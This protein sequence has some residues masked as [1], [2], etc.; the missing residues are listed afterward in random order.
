[1]KKIAI[2][3]TGIMG[4]GMA[5][6]FLKADHEVFVW[7]RNAEKL[8]P[9]LGK[10]AKA[11]RTP[12]DTAAA[13]DIVFEVT[14][15]EESSRAVWL[16]EDG[17]LAGANSDAILIASGTLTA[18]WID[19]LARMCDDQGRIFFDMPLTG[20]R[21]G[22]ENGKLILLVGGDERKLDE[23]KPILQTISEKIWYFGPNGSGI[24]FKLILNMLQGIHLS[25][26][27]EALRIAK[28]SGMDLT[29]V[30]EALAERMGGTTAMAWR[31]RE[32]PEPPN[33]AVKWAH[34]DLTYAKKLAK[35]NPTPILD[36][37]IEQYQKLIDQNLEDKDWTII[38][39]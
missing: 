11:G 2:I 30:S 14:A 1:M 10:G 17:I 20:G 34:K 27:A 7:N 37:A 16:G 6:S 4:N 29:K 28:T 38:T 35:E 21:Y 23:L 39:K 24:R 9:L 12:K 13:A 3:G 22:A 36:Q 8:K 19:E 26:L 25:A 5:L 18:E 32:L 31:D 15:N 33:F